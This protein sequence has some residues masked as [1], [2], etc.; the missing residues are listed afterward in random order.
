VPLVNV[1]AVVLAVKTSRTPRLVV[2]A[3]LVLGHL[4]LLAASTVQ[5]LVAVPLVRA[6]VLAPKV[7][8]RPTRLPS[9]AVPVPQPSRRVLSSLQPSPSSS[10]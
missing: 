9:T 5:L 3:H 10:K 8:V 4:A 1:A 7:V 6:P 2:E